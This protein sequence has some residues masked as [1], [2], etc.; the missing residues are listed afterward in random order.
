MC[1]K[2]ERETDRQTDRQTEI[3][4]EGSYHIKITNIFMEASA[5][6]EQNSIKGLPLGP[7]RL[8]MMPM[9]TENT[10]KPRTFI[11]LVPDFP[12]SQIILEYS[13]I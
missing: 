4:R 10:T 6:Q 9:S 13:E 5:R 7:I 12:G 8:S 11:E 1:Y 2:R 3:E